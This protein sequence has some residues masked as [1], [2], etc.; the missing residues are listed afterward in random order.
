MAVLLLAGGCGG[1]ETAAEQETPAVVETTPDSAPAPET[2]APAAE[3]VFDPE[4]LC[5]LLTEAELTAAYTASDQSRL[6][7]ERG[8]D[9]T[10]EKVD[11]RWTSPERNAAG[12]ESYGCV[13]NE[14]NELGGTGTRLALTYFPPASLPEAD[15]NDPGQESDLVYDDAGEKPH[16]VV[17]DGLVIGDRE[18]NTTLVRL[19]AADGGVLEVGPM[20]ASLE[21]DLLVDLA[22]TAASR[23]AF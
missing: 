17:E 13:W 23:A 7:I 15:F 18:G 20:P 14:S 9:T 21:R 11:A 1:E 16:E 22:R 5:G 19:R 12:I 3:P 6:G 4:E 2:P 10:W 8:T